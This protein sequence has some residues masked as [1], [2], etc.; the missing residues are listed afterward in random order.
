MAYLLLGVSYIN[1]SEPTRAAESVRRAYE[2]RGADKRAGKTRYFVLLRACS[3]PVTSWPHARCTSCG[4]RPTRATTSTGQPDRYLRLLGRT[5][6]SADSGTGVAETQ[7]RKCE[8]RTGIW[9]MRTCCSIAWMRRSHRAS[10]LE[11]TM[12]TGL[13]C[14]SRFTWLISFST[15][16]RMEREAAATDGEAWLRGSHAALLSPKLRRIAGN[17][18]RRGN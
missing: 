12:S 9:V 1:L 16:T 11:P 13:H 15:M 7:P 10:K 14:I 4:R 17:L 18:P 5:R 6:E 3:L 8:S 2:L